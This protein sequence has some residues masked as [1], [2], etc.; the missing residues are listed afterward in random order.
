M[1]IKGIIMMHK[2]CGI[3]VILF[4]FVLVFPAK[5]ANEDVIEDV[6]SSYIEDVESAQKAI[7]EAKD[8]LVR[9]PQM[10]KLRDSQKKLISEGN[11]KRQKLR[12]KIKQRQFQQK[13]STE[14]EADIVAKL[15]P[16][17]L[18][19]Y[20]GAS[21][22]DLEI[23][24]FTLLPSSREGYENVYI[25]Q[26]SSQS[27]SVFKI[28]TGAFGGQ[29]I[30]WDIY[31]QSLPETDNNSVDNG[32]LLYHKYYDYLAKKYG[33]PEEVYVPYIYKKEQEDPNDETKKII[34]EQ[35]SN[36]GGENF[37]Q[38]LQ[39]GK[40]ELYS[41]FTDGLLGVTLELWV[42]EQG[43]S[44]ISIDYKNLLLMQKEEQFSDDNMFE[45]I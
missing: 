16:A 29:G 25:L 26:K 6:M 18:K 42:N 14:K 45:G 4:S 35:K 27:H 31:A 33:N 2:C 13:S 22:D 12:E 43:K 23:L 21:P 44:Y 38:E 37:L 41:T 40:S 34:V 20:W 1:V 15:T 3:G 32:L 30:L 36:I 28:I 5:A 11:I 7:Q 24:G 39:N 9:K 8:S 10:L 17:P 19:L